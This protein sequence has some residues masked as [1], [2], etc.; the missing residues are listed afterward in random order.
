MSRGEVGALVGAAGAGKSTLLRCLTG[1]EPVDAGHVAVE[2]RARLVDGADDLPTQLGIGRH[3]TLACGGDA[4]QARDLLARVGLARRFDDLPA[5]LGAGERQRVRIARALASEPALLLCDEVAPSF[6]A[7]VAGEV[8][9][10]ALALAA[11]GLAV[12]LATADGDFARGAA[13]RVLW[14]RR[15]RIHEAGPGRGA[16][17]SSRARSA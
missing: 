6:D 10:A 4:G 3:L 9:A 12:L 1:R 15:G 16:A 13:D 11:D 5:A 8:A 2:G 7:E 17:M 14:L